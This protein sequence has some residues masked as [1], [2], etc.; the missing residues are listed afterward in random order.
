MNKLPFSQLVNAGFCPW[1]ICDMMHF[2]CIYIYHVTKCGTKNPPPMRSHL[3]DVLMY[4]RH[5][6]PILDDFWMLGIPSRWRHIHTKHVVFCLAVQ[7]ILQTFFLVK[8][9]PFLGF[10]WWAKWQICCLSHGDLATKPAFTPKHLN[11]RNNHLSPKLYANEIL[12]P[13]QV[14]SWTCLQRG[15]THIFS[16]EI[17]QN[18]REL[19]RHRITLFFFFHG[20]KHC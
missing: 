1:L 5:I 16:T 14:R 20:S 12:Q 9:Q 11:R 19:G 10:H 13:S 7:T 3:P 8:S 4:P 2:L 17:L 6:L 15:R 18:T